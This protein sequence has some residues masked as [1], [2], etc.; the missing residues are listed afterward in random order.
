L[1]HLV[2]SACVAY[3]VGFVAG[4]I[5]LTLLG[6]VR[7]GMPLEEIVSKVGLQAI[8]ASMGA[9]LAR[10]QL[11]NATMRRRKRSGATLI[12]ASCSWP[13]PALCSWR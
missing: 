6:V 11:A 13:R 3:A 9:M 2:L 12:S 5:G 4:G 10:S 7:L 8:P 1:G